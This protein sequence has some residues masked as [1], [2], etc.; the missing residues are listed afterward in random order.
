MGEISHEQKLGLAMAAMYN[1]VNGLEYDSLAGCEPGFLNKR[2]AKGMLADSWGIKGHDELV[3]ALK[4][5]YE[6][7]HR[8]DHA[9]EGHEPNTI[10][11]WDLCRLINLVRMGTRVEYIDEKEG[12][13]WVMKSSQLMQSAFKSWNEVAESFISGRSYWLQKQEMEDDYD[14]EMHEAAETLLDAGND[15]S[16]WNQLRFPGSEAV[17]PGYEDESKYFTEHGEAIQAGAAAIATDR[18]TL[19]DAISGGDAS[20]VKTCLASAPDLK[21]KSEDGTTPLSLAIYYGNDEIAKLLLDA[22]ADPN[23]KN[24]YDVPLLCYAIDQE[25]PK[26]VKRLLDAGA[27]PNA[28]NED[29]WPALMMALYREDADTIRAVIAAKPDLNAADPDG[30]TILHYAISNENAD[31]VKALVAAGADVNKKNGDGYMPLEIAEESEMEEI[32]KVLKKAG[33]K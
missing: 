8:A 20:A 23:G 11:A 13:D 19:N 9:A 22:G 14:D 2:A 21:K 29:G 32:V 3:G 27:N 18:D 30:V 7:G 15:E 25:N 17:V 28:K 5:L 24:E 1:E 4:W 6:E 10:L 33:A 16:I 31:Q 26:M 12:W